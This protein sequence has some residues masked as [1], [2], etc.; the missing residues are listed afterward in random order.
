M[1]RS[2][3]ISVSRDVM[4]VSPNK[5]EL[6]TIWGPFGSRRAPFKSQVCAQRY[7]R[8]CD[9]LGVRVQV[10]LGGDQRSVPSDLPE[11]MDRHTGIGHPGQAGVPQVVTAQMLVAKLGDHLV[12]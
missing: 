3:G 12:P 8:V 4:P 6:G 7:T 9:G 5:P 11:H 1:P 10:A 2:A